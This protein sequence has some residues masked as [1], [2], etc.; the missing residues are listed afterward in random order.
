MIFL[1][2]QKQRDRALLFLSYGLQQQS[3]RERGQVFVVFGGELTSL[4]IANSL[5]T[6]HIGTAEMLVPEQ[7]R[8]PRAPIH[9]TGGTEQVMLS[10]LLLFSELVN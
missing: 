4:H 7:S 8:E 6:S 3:L 1:K 9:N 10:C 5:A 2:K